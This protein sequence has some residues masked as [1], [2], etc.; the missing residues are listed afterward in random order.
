[1]LIKRI[2]ILVTMILLSFSFFSVLAM[3]QEKVYKETELNDEMINE[4][5]SF[6]NSGGCVKKKENGECIRTRSFRPELNDQSESP[7][8]QLAS[9]SV[10]IT[11]ETNS[12]ELTPKAK[13]ALDVIGRNLNHI[14]DSEFIIEGHADLRGSYELNQRL[15]TAR[16]ESVMNYLANKH[17]I[18]RGKLSAIGKS[19]TELANTKNPTAPE[20]RRVTFIRIEN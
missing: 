9:L 3:A 20:N 7:S 19:Y 16:A 10:M 15:S 6:K 5:L 17:N 13:Q 1:M 8:K 11:F 2:K 14:S 18:D 12:A 4:G